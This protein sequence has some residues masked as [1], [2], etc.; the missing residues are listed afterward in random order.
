PMRWL[1]AISH[2]R[3]THTAAPNFAYDLCVKRVKPEQIAA[4]DLSSMIMAGNGAEPIRAETLHRFIDTF[5]PAGFDPRAFFPC[6]GTAETTLY[7]SGNQVMRGIKTLKIARDTLATGT[8]IGS[9]EGDMELVS[10]GFPDIEMDVAIVDPL[11]N[12]RCSPGEVGEIW[13]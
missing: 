9:A 6:Y 3:A 11:T 2:Y 12:F 13:L 10:S 4:L 1:E 7:V 5:A 8:V